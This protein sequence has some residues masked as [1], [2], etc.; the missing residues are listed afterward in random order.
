MKDASIVESNSSLG[1]IAYVKFLFLHV[2]SLLT[3]RKM[4]VV[5]EH[6]RRAYERYKERYWLKYNH[7]NV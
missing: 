1:E 7:D 6:K 5:E 2:L 3:L 4:N